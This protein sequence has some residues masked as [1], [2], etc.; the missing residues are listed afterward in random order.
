[1]AAL[2]NTFRVLPGQVLARH[3]LPAQGTAAKAFPLRDYAEAGL[4]QLRVFLRK[5]RT[6]VCAC[7]CTCAFARMNACAGVLAVAIMHGCFGSGNHV[8]LPVVHASVCIHII[9][10][11][12]KHSICVHTRVHIC[13]M[14][15]FQNVLM[16]SCFWMSKLV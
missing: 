5:E 8:C 13:M 4:S 15:T 11:V 12:Y 6:P 2:L 1:M 14:H 16:H 10:S 7:V 3:V 9:A